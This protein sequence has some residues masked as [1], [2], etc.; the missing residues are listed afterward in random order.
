MM[1]PFHT[2]TDVADITDFDC[3]QF[4]VEMFRQ[5]DKQI[6]RLAGLGIEADLIL[7]HPYD[8]WGFSNMNVECDKLY[9]NYVVARY[10][11]YR[12]VW[13]SMANEYD[14]MTKT[15]EEWED[16][17]QTVKKADPYG[18][19][20]SI[21]NCMRFYDYHK[22][23][24]THCSMQRID[25]YK[26][27]E[28][29]GEYLEE[30]KKPVIW[31][32]IC[33]EGN[34]DQGWGNI[35]G[36]ELVRRFWEACLRGGFAGHGETYVGKHIWWSHGG[37]LYGTSAPRIKF[38]RE[39]L[40]QTPGKFLKQTRRSFDEVVGIPYQTKEKA[41]RHFFDPVEY[42]DYEIHYYGF[43]RPAYR[44][45]EFP[46]EER[47]QVDVIDTWNMTVT[48]MGIHSGYTRIMLPGREYMAIRINRI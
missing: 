15:E 4:N 12:N 19:L 33:Y 14:L 27:V 5:F 11:A 44:T 17:A 42:A 31:D 21:H 2:E 3:Y 29:T 10:A 47:F 46:E 26:H 36:E 30:Y 8:K 16:L 41:D 38:L 34:V 1:L 25:F 35:S 24:I 45:F 9:L 43:G 32:E 37:V 6:A 13:W 20:I 40:E 18:H 39:I 7:M 23:W 28:Q 22:D 48:D